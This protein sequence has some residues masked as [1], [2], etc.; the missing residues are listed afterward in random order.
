[1]HIHWKTKCNILE[2]WILGRRYCGFSYKK[3]L[4]Y[5]SNI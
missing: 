5:Q 2:G 3:H 1:M 4:A